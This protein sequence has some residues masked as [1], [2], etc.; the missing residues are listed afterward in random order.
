MLKTLVKKSIL[1]LEVSTGYEP[2][3]LYSIASKDEI[4]RLLARKSP[5]F[6]M[7]LSDFDSFSI[8]P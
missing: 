4:H 7:E 6:L 1:Y 3:D 2:S 8:Y 5:E